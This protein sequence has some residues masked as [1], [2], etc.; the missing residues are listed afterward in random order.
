M[1]TVIKVEGVCKEYRLGVIGSGMLYHDLQSFWARLRGRDDP[2]A[3][4]IGSHKATAQ[5][6]DRIQALDQV[7]FD[8]AAGEVLGVIGPNGAGK[9]TLLKILSRVTR[10]TRGRVKVQGRIAPL[11][12]VGAGFHS[13]LTGRENI[14]LNASI[15]G[16]TKKE[17]H[18]RFDEI[19]AF[20]ELER[21]IDTPV[22][23]Y[24]SGM[25][26]R[27]AF[28]VAAHLDS[29]IL[30]VDEILAVGDLAFQKKC[31]GKMGDVA[32]R[33][34]TILFVSHSMATVA[35]LCSRA[36]LIS[37]GKLVRQGPTQDIID[38]HV[39]SLTQ[40]SNVAILDRT[41][42]SGDGGIRMTGLQIMDASGGARIRSSSSLD[43]T[44]DYASEQRATASR[45]LLQIC[46]EKGLPIYMLDSGTDPSLMER[47][48]QHGRLVCSTGP[49][50]L[51]P[52]RCFVTVGIWKGRMNADYLP[53][54]AS[55][56]VEPDDRLSAAGVINR[57]AAVAMIDQSWTL[58]DPPAQIAGNDVDTSIA[59][60]PR[61]PPRD[62]AQQEIS[63]APAKS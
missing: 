4:L 61:S 20:S 13:E 45:I 47:M 42:R 35:A 23:R 26:V 56:D 27:L 9:T 33:N 14:Y 60:K 52:G 10:P 24:S 43:I 63:G 41:D 58:A 8:V 59:G 18:R 25:Y 1:S 3:K 19:V 40:L 15:L 48:P 31:L 57:Q 38:E 54:A 62:K 34:R 12:E 30:L 17:T 51:S 22:K 6:N 53:H 39:Q 36:L 21:F 37:N 49:I 44:L 28:S 11:L 55:F 2:N 29:E 46:N 32:K 16:M 7:S 50:R 5:K